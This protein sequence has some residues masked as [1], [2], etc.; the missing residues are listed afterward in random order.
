MVLQ[1]K[2]VGPW[3]DYLFGE[4]VY[5]LLSLSSKSVLA[6]KCNQSHF[7]QLK[8][9]HQCIARWQFIEAILDA[10]QKNTPE[11]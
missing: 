7:C 1:Y 2:R 8:P 11:G 4:R 6:R 3:H 10:N 5:I 9:G